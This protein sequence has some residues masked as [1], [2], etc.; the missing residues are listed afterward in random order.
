[1]TK[2]S[3]DFRDGSSYRR[4]KFCEGLDPGPTGDRLLCERVIALNRCADKT[5]TSSLPTGWQRA[6]TK[7]SFT[8]DRARHG[9]A[10]RRT[11]PRRAGSTR[12]SLVSTRS[13]DRKTATPHHVTGCNG[14]RIVPDGP[15]RKAAWLVC[16]AGK[17]TQRRHRFS[18]VKSPRGT[19]TNILSSVRPSVCHV[20]IF[21]TCAADVKRRRR[22]QIPPARASK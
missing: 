10:R 21:V 5:S 1:M 14:K 18:S 12:K 8:P 20:R 19:E 13:N 17:A 15:K 16:H 22:G 4:P 11:V 3:V 2:N 6:V 7:G 9:S